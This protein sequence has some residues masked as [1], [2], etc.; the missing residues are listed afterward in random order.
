MKNV[1]RYSA[2]LVLLL[3]AALL[4]ARAQTDHAVE[5]SPILFDLGVSYTAKVAQ[6]SQQSNSKFVM[7]GAAFDGVWWLPL[8]GGS[9]TRLGVALEAGG[10]SASQIE[11]G[12]SLIEYNLVA[13]PRFQVWKAK[14][15]GHQP[16]LYAQGLVGGV[17]ATDATFPTKPL[18]TTNRAKSLEVETGGGLNW[19]LTQ[20]LGVR[21]FEV[22]YVYT[23]LPNNAD[24]MQNDLRFS[25]GLTLHF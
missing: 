19:P 13:G 22:D 5:A 21:V 16:S 9:F 10:E 25:T 24:R 23:R 7:N 15:K 14:G 2:V 17:L 11:P 8:N 6:V 1:K 18:G 4:P 12:V 20:R 3:T